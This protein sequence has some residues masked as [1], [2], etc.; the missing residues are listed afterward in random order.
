MRESIKGLNAR[1]LAL[2]RRSHRS[3]SQASV[4]SCGC[5]SFWCW[6]WTSQAAC[7]HCRKPADHSFADIDFSADGCDVDPLSTPMS[8]C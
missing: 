6:T 5:L 7:L 4:C 3:A 1:Q 2:T 8:W